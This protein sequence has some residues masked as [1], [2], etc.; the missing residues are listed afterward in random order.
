[1]R[2]RSADELPASKPRL[3]EHKDLKSMK[4]D[5]ESSVGGAH[6]TKRLAQDTIVCRRYIKE[7][8]GV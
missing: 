3:P 5:Q 6:L 8:R 1:M 2:D 4:N 7:Q